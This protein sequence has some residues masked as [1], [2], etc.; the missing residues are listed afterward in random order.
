MLAAKYDLGLS[1]ERVT[2]LDAIDM[3]VAGRE[4]VNL[5]DAFNSWTASLI[6]LV[7]D[8]DKLVPLRS[9]NPN[10]RI[11]NLAITNGDDRLFIAGAFAG[12]MARGGRKMETVVLDD[13]LEAEVKKA[14]AHATAADVV[15]ASLYGRV[16]S[17]K[18]AALVF[19]SREQKRSHR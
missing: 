15:V 12:E 14:L 5:V 11:F 3:R 2:P 17:G 7:R 10:A 8:D 1:Q 4:S 13:V 9:M 19:R 18:R 16:R 6:T